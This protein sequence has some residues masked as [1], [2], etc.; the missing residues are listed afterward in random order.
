MGV[1]RWP[2]RILFIIWKDRVGG[3]ALQED[4]LDHVTNSCSFLET[5]QFPEN[6]DFV[7][8]TQNILSL[9]RIC[10]HTTYHPKILT[11]HYMTCKHLAGKH[12]ALIPWHLMSGILW[13]VEWDLAATPEAKFDQHRKVYSHCC[14]WLLLEASPHFSSLTGS[15]PNPH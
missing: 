6:Q 13:I 2:V 1:L 8:L 12:Q 3:L 11:W 7:W 10:D 4:T 5:L 15:L 14:A 9:A